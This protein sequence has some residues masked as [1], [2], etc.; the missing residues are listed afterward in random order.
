MGG[1]SS[2]QQPGGVLCCSQTSHSPSQR[3]ELQAYRDRLQLTSKQLSV[4][5]VRESCDD[6]YL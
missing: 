4:S 2:L 6:I 1:G 5:R 3:L